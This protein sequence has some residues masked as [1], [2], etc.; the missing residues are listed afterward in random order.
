MPGHDLAHQLLETAKS[1]LKALSNMTDSEAFDDRVFGFHAQ[2]AVEKALK[3]WLNSVQKS[4]PFTHDLSLLL[5]TLKD[6][7]HDVES[8]WAFLDLSGYAV[9]FR[10]DTLPDEGEPL[11]REALLNEVR[12]LVE[13]VETI[14]GPPPSAST[15]PLSGAK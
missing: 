5:G 6:L 11:E 3:A 14:L 8:Y 7:G 1:D 2:Q 12:A 10:Y 9:Q 13:R 15:R 4:H